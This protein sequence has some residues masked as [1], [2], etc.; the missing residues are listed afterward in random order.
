MHK[1]YNLVLQ[2]TDGV[3]EGTS[4]ILQILAL[5]E[6]APAVLAQA[7]TEPSQLKTLVM[8]VSIV[9]TGIGVLITLVRLSGQLGKFRGTVET[10]IDG[11]NNQL[12]RNGEMLDRTDTR[13]DSI[14]NR[15]AT[16]EEKTKAL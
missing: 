10:G 15:M 14:D 3:L 16:L 7:A 12:K 5:A 2:F 13:V 6:A 4:V 8:V 11:I 1:C 9:G